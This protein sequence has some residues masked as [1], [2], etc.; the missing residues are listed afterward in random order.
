VRWPPYQREVAPA[1]HGFVFLRPEPYSNP[2]V[3]GL[4]SEH[5]AIR[6]VGPFVI[7]AP[8][9]DKGAP[10]AERAVIGVPATGGST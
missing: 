3:T 4:R 8:S 1:R 2:I 10:T 6:N 7:Y 5:Y 9:I